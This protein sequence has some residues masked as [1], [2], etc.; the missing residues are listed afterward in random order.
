MIL[1]TLLEQLDE[2]SVA[3]GSAGSSGNIQGTPGGSSP[4]K[5]TK[6]EKDEKDEEPIEEVAIDP[7]DISQHAG[8]KKLTPIGTADSRSKSSGIDDTKYKKDLKNKLKFNNVDRAPYYKEGD[9]ITDLVEKVLRNIIR[10]N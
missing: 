8:M 5:I 6:K 4:S 10:M 2:M 9:I 7:L 1:S 3:G